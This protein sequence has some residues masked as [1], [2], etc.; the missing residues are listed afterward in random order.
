MSDPAPMADDSSTPGPNSGHPTTF[1]LRTSAAELGQR[2]DAYLATQLGGVSRSRIRRAIDQGLV[3]LDGQQCKPSFRLEGEHQI[4]GELPAA[5]EGPQPQAIDLSVLYE[6]EHLAVIDKPAGMVVHPAKGHWEGT[7]ASALV[8]RFGQLS[9]TGGAARPGIV[10]RLDRDTSGAIVVAKT[11][12]IHAALAGQFHDRTVEKE[13]LA[14]VAGRLDR[15]RDR[16]SQPIGPH[17]SS[18]EKMALRADHPDSRAAETFYEVR[19]RFPGFALVAAHPKTGRTHQIRLHLAH[20]G[21]PVLCDRLY[22]GRARITVGELR[23]ITQ[24][25]RLAAELPDDALL[26]ERQA[27]HARQ[28]SVT[29]PVTGK[30]LTV[31]AP[32]PADMRALLSVLRQTADAG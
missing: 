10:H 28:L 5:A 8:H 11:D 22:G 20:V 17:P 21:A 27:L 18:R 6:D 26:L 24:R 7:L 32:L 13:Y 3:L 19:E 29:H 1:S 9:A 25:K 4:A 12:E 16:V 15:D 14:I 31:T 2:L 23:K 30:R